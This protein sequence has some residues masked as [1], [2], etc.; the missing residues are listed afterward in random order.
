METKSSSKE[1][2]IPVIIIVAVGGST[3]LAM[4]CTLG[5]GIFTKWFFYPSIAFWMFSISYLRYTK[6]SKWSHFFWKLCQWWSGLWSILFILSFC[7]PSFSLF[8]GSIFIPIAA[9]GGF[10]PF[11]AAFA[12]IMIWACVTDI[13][14]DNFIRK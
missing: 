9:S 6:H 5:Y 8:I 7:A 12:H 3:L 10:N 13:L 11:L 4:F 1:K 14:R 2:L